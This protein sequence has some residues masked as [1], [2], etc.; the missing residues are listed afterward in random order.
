VQNTADFLRYANPI[1]RVQNAARGAALREARTQLT[2]L[3]D[4]DLSSAEAHQRLLVQRWQ[5]ELRRLLE[6]RRRT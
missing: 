2:L 3:Q 5:R 1:T 4:L 6:P